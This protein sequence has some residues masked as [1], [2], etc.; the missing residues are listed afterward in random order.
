[1]VNAKSKGRDK[2]YWSEIFKKWEDSNLTGS[3][4]CRVHGIPNHRFWYWKKQLSIVAE[5]RDGKVFL[6]V[7]VKLPV[8]SQAG[9]DT[10][11]NYG[12]EILVAGRYAVRVKDDFE[13]MALTRVI[14]VLEVR[15]C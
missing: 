3:A 6:P 8:V 9:P 5:P 2:D 15:G 12:I 4:F 10:G 13:A 1:M 7:D 11:N 14:G